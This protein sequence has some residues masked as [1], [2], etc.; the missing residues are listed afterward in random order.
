MVALYRAGRR[1]D[2]LE[3]FHRLRGVLLHDLGLEPSQRMR[4]LQHAILTGDPAL[5]GEASPTDQL[6][7]GGRV[8]TP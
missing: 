1:P 4:R 7:G 3:A 6:V 2:A 5:D 8:A